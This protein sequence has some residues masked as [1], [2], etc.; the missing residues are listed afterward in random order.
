MTAI[1]AHRRAM[2]HCMGTLYWQLND[3]WQVSSWSSVDYT[4]RWK[5][6]HY[7]VKELYG[8][9][10]F[11][12]QRTQERNQS[13]FAIHLASDIPHDTSGALEM[14][15]RSFDGKVLWSKT[16]TI[17]AKANTAQICAR[18]LDTEL[19]KVNAA[20][21]VLAVRFK[22]GTQT[23]AEKLYYFVSPK[24]LKLTPPTIDY[25]LTSS[26]TGQVLTL[27]A[28]TLAKNVFLQ[29]RGEGVNQRN[30]R[31]S[32]NFFD[33]LP[34]ETKIVQIESEKPF[35]ATKEQ[36]LIQSLIDSY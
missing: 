11:S 31:F 16:Q 34:G 18:V 26:P 29:F 30:V 5:A 6:L 9:L 33:L 14:Q 19:P 23:L 28:N 3:C 21:S 27:R 32:T 13:G 35:A 24:D 2:P 1:E 10:L 22:N 8:N 25:T 20:E 7:A 15:L 4:G 36:L 12:V 17:T